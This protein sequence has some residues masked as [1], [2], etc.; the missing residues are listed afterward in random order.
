MFKYVEFI[1]TAY[2]ANQNVLY[3]RVIELLSYAV[4]FRYLT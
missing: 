1:N 3:A 2:N 4:H